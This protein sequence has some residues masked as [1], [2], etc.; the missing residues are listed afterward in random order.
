MM[1]LRVR[2]CSMMR[3]DKSGRH[4]GMQNRRAGRYLVPVPRRQIAK[5][6]VALR[7]VQACRQAGRN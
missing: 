3:T 4:A 7:A 5:G 1:Y 6:S 2:M